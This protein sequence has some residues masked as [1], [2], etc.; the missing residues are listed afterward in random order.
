M[1]NYRFKD[2]DPVIDVLRTAVQMYAEIEGITFNKALANIERGSS[3]SLK[4]L[5]N[6]FYGPTISPIYKNV[7]EVATYLKAEVLIGQRTYHKG[8][9]VVKFKPRRV[10]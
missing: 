3:V 9:N 5:R 1:M 6:W 4:A 2:K 8:R 10:A 7:A